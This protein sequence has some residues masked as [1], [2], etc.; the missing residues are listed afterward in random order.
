MCSCFAEADPE[1]YRFLRINRPNAVTVNGALCSEP[2]LL[3]YSSLGVIPVRGFVEFMTPSFLKQWHG[4]VYNNKTKL[5]DLPT[6]Q[7]M[8]MR[9]LLSLL[10]V[11]HVDLWILDV[12][13]AEES[14]LQV[15]SPYC[16]EPR[17]L[18]YI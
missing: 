1:N 17:L 15:R 18:T 4:P 8:P 12:E 7:C 9:K 5:E 3:H 14:A 6:V 10:G 11:T 16:Y 2:R 13:G